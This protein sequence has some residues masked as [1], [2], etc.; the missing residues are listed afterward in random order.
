MEKQLSMYRTY[1]YLVLKVLVQ[2][3]G[4]RLKNI[5][6]DCHCS[7]NQSLCAKESFAIHVCLWMKSQEYAKIFVV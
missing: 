6:V 5:Y 4:C 3:H 1:T 7:A 2:K